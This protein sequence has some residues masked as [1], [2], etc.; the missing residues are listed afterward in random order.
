MLSSKVSMKTPLGLL[1]FVL[2]LTAGCVPL[3]R[4][5]APAV[6]AETALALL[7][8]TSAAFAASWESP[9]LP[10][11][12]A[13]KATS[14]GQHPIAVIVGCSDSRTPPEILFRKNL[15]RL[16][17]VRTAGNVV[18]NVALGSI[19]YAVEHLG[20]R[21]VI[22]LGH[23]GCG[24]V[25]ATVAG[26]HVP[27]HIASIVRK[28]RPAVQ[29][30]RKEKGNLLDNSIQANALR[31]ADTIRHDSAIPKDLSGLKVVPAIYEIK[32]GKVT[33]LE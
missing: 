14:E 1:P 13:R 17:V 9:S 4:A 7:K 27:P 11:A 5:D 19:E 10:V 32:T 2:L 25:K 33:W 3:L 8:K 31:V 12:E 18:D 15:G 26:G 20:V 24:A 23:T 22:V 28:I 16:F 29:E 6:P 30:A 21:L